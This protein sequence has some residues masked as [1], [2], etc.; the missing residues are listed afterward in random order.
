MLL[1]SLP[2]PNT[3]HTT[4]LTFLCVVV[5]P[6]P[7]THTHTHTLFLFFSSAFCCFFF[8]LLHTRAFLPHN[9]SRSLSKVALSLS[10]SLSLPTQPHPTSTTH[11]KR[12]IASFW[13]QQK[14]TPPPRL[15]SLVLLMPRNT[16]RV[17]RPKKKEHRLVSLVEV[18]TIITLSF[19]TRRA[20]S[21]RPFYPS[22]HAP[23]LPHVI[24]TCFLIE[25]DS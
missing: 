21:G 11:K 19:L 6:P 2:P 3:L 17:P 16:R 10:L 24:V 22:P 8:A 5:P 25:R 23:T 1:L 7:P 12:A 18:S 9:I 14:G 13:P 20:S 4:L 15:P